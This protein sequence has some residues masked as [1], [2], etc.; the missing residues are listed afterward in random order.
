MRLYYDPTGIS[1]SNI[2]LVNV[3]MATSRDGSYKL[4]YKKR[5]DPMY[6]YIDIPDEYNPLFK[7]FRLSLTD[8]TNKESA[9]TEP[10]VVDSLT[11][12]INTV[13]TNIG[14]TGGAFGDEEYITK[15]KE[16]LKVHIGNDNVQYIGESDIGFIIQLV[17]ISC[18][19][20]LAYDN[21]RYTRITLPDGISLDKGERVAHYLA[22]AESMMKR[23]NLLMDNL[24]SNGSGLVQT[25]IIKK[26]FYDRRF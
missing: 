24:N 9:Q 18:C 4:T 14:D 8:D 5:F 25:K 6:D 20:D 22:I 2:S 7:W 15:I 11:R 12:I 16:S 21:A 1:G 17:M 23:Y 3:Y 19:Y 13:R 26:S 10:F